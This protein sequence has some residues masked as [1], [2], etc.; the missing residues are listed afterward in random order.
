[1]RKRS[2]FRPQG[3]NPV[4]HVVAMKGAAPLD[5]R[6]V[7]SFIGPVRT[8]VQQVLTAAETIDDWRKI[9]RAIN[10]C[11]ALM[12]AR[13]SGDKPHEYRGWLADV[14][15]TVLAVF[16][17]RQDQPEAALRPEEAR[18]LRSICGTYETALRAVN[19]RQMLDAERKADR[20]VD[21]AVRRPDIKSGVTAIIR[22]PPVQ[23]TR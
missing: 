20:K 10:V 6:D 4:A 22:R 7:A 16:G 19:C 1:M 15:E 17:R 8:A 2:R 11:E 9:F 12:E 14:Q 3:V 5:A 23:A 21:Q 18:S 13:V